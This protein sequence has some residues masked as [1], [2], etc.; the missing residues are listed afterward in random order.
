MVSNHR[1]PPVFV[2][3]LGLKP[4]LGSIMNSCLI[5]EELV[6]MKNAAGIMWPY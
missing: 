3:V 6:F 5:I 1:V 4:K 2:V